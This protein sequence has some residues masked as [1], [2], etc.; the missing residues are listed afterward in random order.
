[1]GP[2]CSFCG[3]RCFLIRI[4]PDGPR[5]GWSGLMATCGKGMALDREATG[6][7]HTTAVNPVTDPDAA[8]AVGRAVAAAARP[9]VAAAEPSAAEAAVFAEDLAAEVE[10]RGWYPVTVPHWDAP[11]GSVIEWSEFGPGLWRRNGGRWVPA[12]CCTLH[13]PQIAGDPALYPA[14]WITRGA[15]IAR[16][17]DVDTCA[18]C[19]SSCPTCPTAVTAAAAAQVGV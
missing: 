14:E 17:C 3:I 2:Y 10:R 9:T 11:D 12:A 19:C 4:V 16:C 8:A 15:E 6:H 13:V 7:D 18:P 1:M 5:I